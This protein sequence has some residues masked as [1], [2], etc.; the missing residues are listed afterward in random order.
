[1]DDFALDSTADGKLLSTG[2]SILEQL[3]YK[4]SPVLGTQLIGYNFTRDNY[5]MVSGMLPVQ[6]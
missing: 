3:A 6:S 4:D 5:R 1:M 2:W